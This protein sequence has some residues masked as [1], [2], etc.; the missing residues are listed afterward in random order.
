MVSSR[1]LALGLVSFLGL[2]GC[3]GSSPADWSALDSM[4]IDGAFDSFYAPTSHGALTLG[5]SA[6]VTVTGTAR[7]HE[8]SFE[9][10]SDGAITLSTSASDAALVRIYLYKFEAGRWGRYVARSED[11]GTLSYAAGAGQY[12]VVVATRAPLEG[13]LTLSSACT[14]SCRAPRATGFMIAVLDEDEQ[15]PYYQ[16]DDEI[17][18][19]G[20]EAPPRA[21]R[22]EGGPSG[23]AEF[24]RWTARISEYSEELEIPAMSQYG[25]PDDRYVVCYFGEAEHVA[26]V[27]QGMTDSVFSDMFTIGGSRTDLGATLGEDEDEEGFL[28]WIGR[29]ADTWTSFDGSNGDVAVAWTASDGGDDGSVS[30]ITRCENDRATVDELEAAYDAAAEGAVY[31]SE[32][33]SEP[34]LVVGDAERGAIDEARIRAAFGAVLSGTH[35]VASLDE[36]A[37]EFETARESLVSL[38]SLAELDADETDESTIESARAFGRIEQLLVGGLTGIRAVKVGPADEDGSLATD[39]GLY[40]WLIVGWTREGR[41]AGIMYTSVET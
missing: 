25:T 18:G 39:Q 8:W 30:I 2:I 34:E 7:F 10:V 31:I 16:F 5:A 35:D 26:D 41:L 14:G 12:R 15:E 6:G 1:K 22:V 11:A 20:H 19:A 36:L 9:L 28:S 13:A 21:I 24:D 38:T 29:D 37:F 3:G 17:T 33:D 27:M 23:L 4:P 40:T 32:S